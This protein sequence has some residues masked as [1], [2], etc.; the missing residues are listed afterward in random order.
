MYIKS[1]IVS[2][3]LATF[4]L[5]SID[6]NS[7]ENNNFFNWPDLHQNI[8]EKRFEEAQKIIANYPEQIQQ[9]TPFEESL[10]MT[11][12]PTPF[13]VFGW[14]G[15]LKANITMPPLKVKKITILQKINQGYNL[16]LAKWHQGLNALE[17]AIE[18][19]AIDLAETLLNMGIDP[20]NQLADIDSSSFRVVDRFSSP[21]HRFNYHLYRPEVLL[22]EVS[23]SFIS[24]LYKAIVSQN[25]LLTELLL[26]HGADS[27][28]V[29]LAAILKLSYVQ[30]MGT[31]KPNCNESKSSYMLEDNE[32]AIVP[33]DSPRL[34]KL[35]GLPYEYPH[36]LSITGL[37]YGKFSALQIASQQESPNY[38]ILRILISKRGSQ[39]IKS[40]DI[41]DEVIEKYMR[42][43]NTPK[44]MLKAA[45]QNNDLSA[46]ITFLDFEDDPKS[47]EDLALVH[48]E[49]EYLYF[50]NEKLG[51]SND[52]KSL[53]IQKKIYQYSQQSVPAL[54]YAISKNDIEVATEIMRLYPDQIMM[55][56][57]KPAGSEFFP[58]SSADL[59]PALRGQNILEIAVE[60]NCLEL[61]QL[62]LQMGI[63]PNQEILRYKLSSEV[64]SDAYTYFT[65]YRFQG[66]IITSLGIAQK[67]NNSEITKLLLKYGAIPTEPRSFDFFHSGKINYYYPNGW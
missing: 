38:E 39:K 46:F 23:T 45:L 20:N 52:P 50:V 55:L 53:V 47:V 54:H 40:N 48:P 60:N 16:N 66:E 59:I 49:N 27:E 63:D 30:T 33:Y 7:I 26:D 6:I 19:G 57:P 25:T 24:P 67:N 2:L 65:R 36:I 32:V 12:E 8:A 3:F 61:A 17:V 35:T 4:S 21:D 15:E 11:H 31:V 51:V 56:T 41:S 22:F 44:S 37:P 62:F 29:Q 34:L 9:T 42:Y 1:I 18:T 64:I 13:F 14:A 10:S 28:F 43:S 58:A 5:F